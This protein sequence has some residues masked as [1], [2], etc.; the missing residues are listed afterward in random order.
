MKRDKSRVRLTM[1]QLPAVNTPQFDRARSHLSKRLPP[2]PP[3]YQPEAIASE[4]V[5]AA[6]YAPRELW[7][8]TQSD[9]RNYAPAVP[10]QDRVASLSLSA[11]ANRVLSNPTP[12]IGSGR[13]TSM[14]RSIARQRL[15]EKEL[16]RRRWGHRT[17]CLF[18][19]RAR[20]TV[21]K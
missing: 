16:A 20:E 10:N 8:G 6:R 11:A 19:P 5:R 14:V 2:V 15:G 18:R 17:P 1:V 3:I 9:Y 4:I 7:I 21:T 12:Y 13:S